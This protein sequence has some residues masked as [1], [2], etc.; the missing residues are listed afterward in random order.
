MAEARAAGDLARRIDERIRGDCESGLVPQIVLDLDG[1]LFDNVP[2][3]KQILL[4]QSRSLFG[5]DAGITTTIEGLAE[6][7][8]EYNPV[9]TLRKHGIEDEPTLVRLREAW[10]RAFFGSDYLLHDAPLNGGVAAARAWW[11]KGAELNYLTG[12]H[13]PDMYL[14]TS[15]SLHDAGFPIGTIRTQLLM[16]PA[17]DLNDVDFKIETVPLIRRK[18]PIVLIVDNDPRVLNPLAGEVPEAISVMV[19]T[20]H[21]KDA[22]EL[23]GTIPIVEDFRELMT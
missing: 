19:R 8:F 22:P 16:K 2:R 23:T 5:P 1:T 18:G 12:R 7:A 21:P 4:D 14:G 13:V 11:E 6:E 9:D 15:R 20:L 3:T 10:A 17:F